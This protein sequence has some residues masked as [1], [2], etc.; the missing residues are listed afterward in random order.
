MR[1]PF[2]VVR[3]AAA[4][5]GGPVAL[6]AFADLRQPGA[7]PWLFEVPATG[8]LVASCAAIWGRLPFAMRATLEAQGE[9]RV[10]FA[11][12]LAR[13]YHRGVGR[14]R[15]AAGP[16]LYVVG[17]PADP[18]VL[19]HDEAAIAEGWAEVAALAGQRRR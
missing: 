18:P 2:R 13:D 11:R 3:P 17:A 12:A 8:F 6:F 1:A 7:R 16:C 10:S 14:G 9:D 5:P 15:P 4:R 19:C